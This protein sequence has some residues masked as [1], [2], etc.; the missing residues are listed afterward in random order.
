MVRQESND[1]KLLKEARRVI[2]QKE[3]DY[4]DMGYLMGLCYGISEDGYENIA[5]NHIWNRLLERPLK[6][7][8]FHFSQLKSL[9]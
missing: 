1:A 8:V 5:I 9:E 2:K 4:S 7:A 3:L 6:S